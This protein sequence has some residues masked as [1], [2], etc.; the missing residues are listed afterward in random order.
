MVLSVACLDLKSYTWIYT[1]EII[2][3]WNEHPIFSLTGN[4][5]WSK[6][7]QLSH[8]YNPDCWLCCS[9]HFYK[10]YVTSIN[11]CLYLNKTKIIRSCKCMYTFCLPDVICKETILKACLPSKASWKECT[12]YQYISAGKKPKK[13]A[14]TFSFE[15]DI[16]LVCQSICSIIAAYTDI[17]IL[18][19]Y[20]Q[21]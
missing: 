13:L 20:W 12:N 18:S 5:S 10:H 19:T 8:C 1:K 21:Y 3:T 7:L 11:S 15:L 2:L 14:T 16:Q 9:E 4:G 17:Y 6:W